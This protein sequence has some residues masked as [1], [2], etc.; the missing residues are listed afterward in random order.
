MPCSGATAK[1]VQSSSSQVGDDSG[2]NG[3]NDY[4]SD[5]LFSQSFCSRTQNFSLYCLLPLAF[6]SFGT[7]KAVCLAAVSPLVLIEM[8]WS[9][10]ICVVQACR[11][12]RPVRSSI[13]R[14]QISCPWL[15][16]KENYSLDIWSFCAVL[17]G[18]GPAEIVSFVC[19]WLPLVTQCAGGEIGEQ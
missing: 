14:Q 1:S 18:N 15:R 5:E 9:R 6:S 10:L 3:D 2:N 11:V 17:V 13:C 8:Q 16:K 7:N 12:G 19:W 4:N